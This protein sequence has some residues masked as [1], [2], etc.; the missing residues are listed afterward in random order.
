[1]QYFANRQVIVS[2]LCFLEKLNRQNR[3]LKRKSMMMMSH[4][5]PETITEIN[6][7]DDEDEGE[8]QGSA[9]R[10]CLS[11]ISNT[12]ISGTRFLSLS[13]TSV[14]T[15]TALCTETQNSPT[16]CDHS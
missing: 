10:A 1:M 5:S 6:L 7:T 15:E 13:N 14:L 12:L 9:S 16:H 11:P 4:L 3:S 8:D 2:S